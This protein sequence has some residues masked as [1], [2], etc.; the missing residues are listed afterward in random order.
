MS[1]SL[2]KSGQ[3]LFGIAFACFPQPL[4]SRNPFVNQV[5]FFYLFWKWYQ[6]RFLCRN[7]FVNQVSFFNKWNGQSSASMGRNPFVNQVSFFA[8]RGVKWTGALIK[9]RNPF[10]NQVSFFTSPAFSASGRQ[11]A[12]QSLRK[13]GQFLLSRRGSQRS[14]VV[15]SQSLRKSGQFLCWSPVN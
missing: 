12:S 10:V 1:Q 4:E 13:S 5:S 7:P 9:R 8:T 2:R 11:R 14:G 6:R 15:V 3:F